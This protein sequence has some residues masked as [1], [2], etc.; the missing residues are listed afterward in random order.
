MAKTNANRNISINNDTYV[1]N[2]TDYVIKRFRLSAEANKKVFEHRRVLSGKL[3]KAG[4]PEPEW[5]DAL[6]DLLKTH[7]ALK[8]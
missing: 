2:S 8:K 3:A 4:Q 6:E 7:P 1:S 5:A